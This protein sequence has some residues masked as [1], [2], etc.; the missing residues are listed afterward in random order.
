MAKRDDDI[1]IRFSP[2]ELELV[3]EALDLL[4]PREDLRDQLIFADLQDLLGLL[5]C[6]NSAKAEPAAAMLERGFQPVYRAGETNRCPG[7]G[8]SHWLVGR[9]TAECAF[10]ATALPIDISRRRG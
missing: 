3:R 10:C 5:G 6:G 2:Q 8:R 1:G 4:P 7:C 9:S